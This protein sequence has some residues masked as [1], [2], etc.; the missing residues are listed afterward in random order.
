MRSFGAP[1]RHGSRPGNPACLRQLELTI[2]GCLRQACV[3]LATFVLPVAAADAQS[4]AGAVRNIEAVLGMPLLLRA[5]RSQSMA[6]VR[7]LEILLYCLGCLLCCL[8]KCLWIEAD[9]METPAI[10][11]GFGRGY[12]RG[13]AV[14]AYT[15]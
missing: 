1:E 10:E 2:D 9:N 5:V 12:G 11:G 8:M 6:M 15:L 7:G 14:C 3:S 4:M 13:Y